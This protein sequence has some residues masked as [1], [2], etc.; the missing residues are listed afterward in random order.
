MAVH[1]RNIVFLIRMHILLFDLLLSGEIL[2]QKKNGRK[3]KI[4]AFL[5]FRLSFGLIPAAHVY[6]EIALMMIERKIYAQNTVRS[7]TVWLTIVHDARILTG[8]PR[9]VFVWQ[10]VHTIF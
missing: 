3:L 9:N 6:T 10:N 5:E 8:F 7:Y 2:K 1:I 4:P